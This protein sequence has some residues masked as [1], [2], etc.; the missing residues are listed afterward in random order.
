VLGRCF[1]MSF[2]F[3]TSAEIGAGVGL[4]GVHIAAMLEEC[5]SSSSRSRTQHK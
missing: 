2:A 1:R 3:H 5:S 4:L